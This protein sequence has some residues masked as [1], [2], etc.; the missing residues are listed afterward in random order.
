MPRADK[1][2]KQVP[3]SLQ[4]IM[5]NMTCLQINT[6]HSRTASAALAQLIIENNYDVVCV[7]E[8]YASLTYSDQTQ[9]PYVRISNIPPGYQCFHNLNNDHA[10]GALI[11][12]RSSLKARNRTELSSNNISAIQF[13][14][15][16]SSITIFSVYLRPTDKNPENSLHNLCSILKND[17]KTSIFCIDSNAKNRLWGST[18]SNAKGL[19]L[20]AAISSN[21]LHLLNR[22]LPECPITPIG[23]S[24]IDITL[25][26]DNKNSN[27]WAYLDLPSLSDHPYIAFN[28]SLSDS[29]TLNTRPRH[30]VPTIQRINT[31]LFRHFY[32][33]SRH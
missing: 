29:S 18:V 8:P 1:S 16:S 10:Y 21:N 20:E 7:Q 17:S 15:N 2:C 25:A 32:H 9:Q 33:Q 28:F 14:V 31:E 26:G 24:F 27:F 19:S 13:K 5:N 23:T 6:R 4:L 11:F 3:Y 30:Q 12:A 22:K